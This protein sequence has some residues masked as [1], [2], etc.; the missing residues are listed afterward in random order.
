MTH[1][2]FAQFLAIFV[3]ASAVHTTAAAGQSGTQAS[4]QPA[5]TEDSARVEP[6]SPP[7]LLNRDEVDRAVRAAHPPLLRDAGVAGMVEI[8]MQVGMNG[9]VDRASITVLNATHEMFEAPAR[10]VAARMQFRPAQRGGV[11]VPAEVTV[12]VRFKLQR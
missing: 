3:V 11:P 4:S 2:T 9:M 10:R 6:V 1:K 7:E 8:R 12:P 5:Q